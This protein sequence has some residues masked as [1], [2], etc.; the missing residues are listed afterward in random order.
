MMGIIK[1]IPLFSLYKDM[2]NK[3]KI[4]TEKRTASLQLVF[5]INFPRGKEIIH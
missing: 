1:R 3:R 5:L 2:K 4:G